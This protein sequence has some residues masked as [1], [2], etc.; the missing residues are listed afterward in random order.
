MRLS[1][2]A[3]IASATAP[4]TIVDTNSKLRRVRDL[5]N[6]QGTSHTLVMSGQGGLI[7]VRC[8]GSASHQA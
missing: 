4:P 7:S 8:C 1:A 3:M 2:E 6:I 5:R